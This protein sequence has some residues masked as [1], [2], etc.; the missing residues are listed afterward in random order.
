MRGL[1]PGLASPHPLGPALPAIYQEDDFAQSFLTAFDDV[2]A[3]IFSTVDNFPACLDPPRPRRLPRLA[4][5]LA[6]G[7]DG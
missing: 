7:D 2:L 3:P 1:V 5:K 4:G 6:R